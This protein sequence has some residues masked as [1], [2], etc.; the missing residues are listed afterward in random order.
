MEVKRVYKNK[1]QIPIH[2]DVFEDKIKVKFNIKFQD[3]RKRDENRKT[4]ERA[5]GWRGL[6]LIN[7][8]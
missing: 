1:Y 3:N 2:M 5:L 4:I 8:D 6:Q 7:I